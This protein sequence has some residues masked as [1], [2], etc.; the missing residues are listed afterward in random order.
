MS[1]ELGRA[2]VLER[3]VRV[4]DG[5]GG[6]AESWVA[7]GTLWA[8]VAPGSGRD[9]AGEEVT[10]ASVPCRITVRAA[11]FGAPSRPV[12][13]QRFREGGRVFAILAVSERDAGGRYL[14]C[15]AREEGPA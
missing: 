10:L 6:H 9:V 4:A 15:F 14:T 8:E 3:P 1:V 2:L 7:L 13:G 11:P 5:A 12:A